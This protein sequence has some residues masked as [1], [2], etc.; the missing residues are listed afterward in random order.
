MQY[1]NQSSLSSSHVWQGLSLPNPHFLNRMEHVLT[2]TTT[3]LSLNHT[4]PTANALTLVVEDP[5]LA[6]SSVLFIGLLIRCRFCPLW[7]LNS[8]MPGAPTSTNSPC[9]T[10]PNA[11]QT[12]RTRFKYSPWCSI[13]FPF[14]MTTLAKSKNETCTERGNMPLQYEQRQWHFVLNWLCSSFGT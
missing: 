3:S 6:L 11:I 5:R 14:I 10:G 1:R 7:R 9:L 8:R 2:L 13:D 12:R 4:N